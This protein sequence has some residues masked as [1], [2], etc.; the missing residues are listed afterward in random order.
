MARKE[1]RKIASAD[2]GNN[3]FKGLKYF[4]QEIFVEYVL[5]VILF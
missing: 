4:I 1:T 2:S 3:S 5:W